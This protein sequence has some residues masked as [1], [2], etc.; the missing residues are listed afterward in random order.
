MAQCERPVDGSCSAKAV[1]SNK[2]PLF[3]S[4]SEGKRYYIR[5]EFDKDWAEVDKEVANLNPDSVFSLKWN[6]TSSSYT[7]EVSLGYTGV[8][9]KF[10]VGTVGLSRVTDYRKN[11]S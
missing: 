6:R 8:S 9:L 10:E 5:A 2:Q 1:R 11:L 4:P 3:P 7:R